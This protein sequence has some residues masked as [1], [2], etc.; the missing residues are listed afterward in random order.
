MVAVSVGDRAHVW[1]VMCARV[2][3][4]MSASLFSNE[5]PFWSGSAY[6]LDSIIANNKIGKQNKS[7]TSDAFVLKY[8]WP[9]GQGPCEFGVICKCHAMLSVTRGTRCSME[10]R[11]RLARPCMPDRLETRLILTSQQRGQQTRHCPSSWPSSVP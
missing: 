2:R 7:N 4:C 8:L 9:M 1:A 6:S 3:A 10:S 5:D 11:Y